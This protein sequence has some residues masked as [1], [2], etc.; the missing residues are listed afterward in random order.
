MKVTSLTPRSL[1]LARRVVDLESTP[2]HFVPGIKGTISRDSRPPP[3]VSAMTSLPYPEQVV[4]RKRPLH[5]KSNNQDSASAIA[6]SLHASK[7][8]TLNAKLPTCENV[9]PITKLSRTSEAVLTSSDLACRRWWDASCLETSKNWWLP[10][11]IDSHVSELS[12]LKQSANKTLQGS[13]FSANLDFPPNRSSQRTYSP[14]STFSAAAC[15]AS[16]ST[17]KQ[18]EKTS[19]P[20][21]EKLQAPCRASEDCAL[22]VDPTSNKFFCADHYLLKV[23]EHTENGKCAGFSTT[24]KS[25]GKQCP[26]NAKFGI[27]C[28]RHRLPPK[29]IEG[30]PVY[31]SCRVYRLRKLDKASCTTLKR[32]FGVARKYYNATVSYLKTHKFKGDIRTLIEDEFRGIDYCDAVPSKVKQEAIADALKAVSNAIKKYKES[33]KRS[34]FRFRSKKH[35]SQSININKDALRPTEDPRE[36]KMYSTIFPSTLRFTEDV[37]ISTSCRMVMKYNRTFYLNSPHVQRRIENQDDTGTEGKG[38]SV[39][40]ID[41]GIRN[42]ISFY[43]ENGCGRI[44]SDTRE[45][46]LYGLVREMDRLQSKYQRLKRKKPRVSQ[47]LKRLWTLLSCKVEHLVSDMHWKAALFLCR[48][49][50]HIV[51]PLY[52]SKGISK[53]ASKM[54]NRYNHVLSH[55]RFRQRLIHKAREFGR[56][57]VLVNESYTSKTCTRCGN[58]NTA[59]R[60]WFRCQ[61][62]TLYIDRD[63]QGA[64]NILLKTFTHIS[65]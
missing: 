3:G 37:N 24:G 11:E 22:P 27:F 26:Y 34:R 12:S 62:C 7:K 54:V 23:A 48:N 44:G 19:K 64:R 14:F 52:S 30:E 49:F 17:A 29:A 43:S 41:P 31:N 33:D 15:T 16:E 2:T 59:G 42:F 21:A 38:G 13:W 20:P 50:Q 28:Q 10:I 5:D 6:E 58:E 8:K 53:K 40:A 9:T 25:K 56:E 55:F 47:K 4:P 57:V 61:R 1:E 51:L 46:K 45:T 32:W 39:V 18:S 65:L 35:L 63:Y 60:D 36:W